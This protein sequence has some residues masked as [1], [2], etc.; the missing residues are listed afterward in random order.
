MTKKK[1][2]KLY[3]QQKKRYLRKVQGTNE[4]PRLSVFRSNKHIYA[5]I[6][7]DFTSRTLVSS[8]TQR[9]TPFSNTKQ[10]AIEVGKAIGLKALNQNIATIAFD[11][12]NRAFHGRVKSL[13]DGARE[14]G[15]FF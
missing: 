9:N 8:S 6:I 14:V 2:K 4:K 11:R 1:E 15:L 3:S 5:Q 7:N 13:A 10:G 12:G